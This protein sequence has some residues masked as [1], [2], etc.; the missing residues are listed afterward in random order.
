MNGFLD[1]L[2]GS[3]R[4]VENQDSLRGYILSITLGIRSHY[5]QCHTNHFIT[6]LCDLNYADQW[7]RC[8][9]SSVIQF[10]CIFSIFIFR[11]FCTISH[12]LYMQL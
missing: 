2:L 7:R 8:G 10:T 12:I 4:R 3:K 6:G 1:A 5:P 11:I 9:H